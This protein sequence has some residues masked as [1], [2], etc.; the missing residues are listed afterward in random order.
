MQLAVINDTHIGV[1]RSA[2]TTPASALALRKFLLDKTA[3]LLGTVNVDLLINGDLFDK[4]SVPFS[5]M[6]TTYGMFA[7]WLANNPTCILYGSP[8]NHDLSKNSSIF[9][10]FQFL[11]QL[12]TMLHPTRV[13]YIA[14]LAEIKPGIW[15]LPHLPNQERLEHALSK[16]PECEVLFVHANFDNNFAVHSDNS[17]N[18]SREQAEACK[19]K[20]IVFGHEHQYRVAMDSKVI[21]PGNQFPSSV[22]DCLGMTQ[23][24]MVVIKD[25]AVTL[26]DVGA[27]AYQ[28]MDWKSLEE[29]TAMFIR[30]TGTAQPEE[31]AEVA[32]K[33]SKYRSKSEAYVITNAVQM[34]TADG[35]MEQFAASLESVRAFDV[36]AALLKHLSPEEQEAIKTLPV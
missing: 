13:Q 26:Q 29:T 34:L 14:D 27:I 7:S 12:L 17:L 36:M 21:V 20:K 11:M 9:S 2:G 6:L 8:G 25:G 31:G 18:I 16:V 32:Q 24:Q 22:S 30:V 15:V 28:E 35:Q 4:E 5:D 23:R 1:L 33:I 3:E 19:A 10:S